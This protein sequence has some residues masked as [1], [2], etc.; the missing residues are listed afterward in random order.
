[1]LQVATDRPAVHIQATHIIITAWHQRNRPAAAAPCLLPLRPP[2]PGRHGPPA[3][4]AP[5]PVCPPSLRPRPIPPASSAWPRAPPPPL[6]LLLPRPCPSPASTPSRAPAD[7]VW[8]VQCQ[9]QSST[10][11]MSNLENIRSTRWVVGWW[12]GGP[13]PR[14]DSIQSSCERGFERRCRS[15]SSTL[16]VT[17]KNAEVRWGGGVGVGGGE[18]PPR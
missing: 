1:M 2:R 14:L 6:A 10:L 18:E 16:N 3:A 9:S 17:L 15:Q 13:Q 12:G 8:N 7:A 11:S 5:Q 4:R